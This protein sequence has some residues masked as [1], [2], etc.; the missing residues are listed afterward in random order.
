MTAA[1]DNPGALATRQHHKENAMAKAVK[2]V[3]PVKSHIVQMRERADELEMRGKAA[4]EEVSRL[5]G[6]L[7]RECR[8]ERAFYTF[9][10]SD[11]VVVECPECGQFW[12]ISVGPSQRVYFAEHFLKATKAKGDAHG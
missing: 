12:K 10:G 2:K 7:A 1:T 5:R 9:E 8:H 3:E 4:L 11:V 6:R